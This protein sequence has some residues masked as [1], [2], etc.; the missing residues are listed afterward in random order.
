M[1]SFLFSV[2]FS[3]FLSLDLSVSFCL[4]HSVSISLSLSFLPSAFLSLFLSLTFTLILTLSQ[5]F[6]ESISLYLRLVLNSLCSAGWTQTHGNPLPWLAKYWD[7][8]CVTRWAWG[9]DTG[10][11]ITDVSPGGHGGVW[12]QVLGSQVSHQVGGGLDAG[13]HM[14]MLSLTVI[15]SDPPSDTFFN[16]DF[17]QLDSPIDFCRGEIC[18]PG[19]VLNS[20]SI[21]RIQLPC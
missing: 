15:F 4:C 19:M 13:L 21:S 18:A 12:M 16:F 6:K 8:R 5:L 11:E 17:F 14:H 7:H 10:V 2:S 3:L 20:P 1:Q 9:L